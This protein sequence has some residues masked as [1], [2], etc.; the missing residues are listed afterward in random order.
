VGRK[1]LLST[2]KFL[3]F[4]REWLRQSL[5][6][7][8]KVRRI[9]LLRAHWSPEKASRATTKRGERAEMAW[10]NDKSAIFD[11]KTIDPNGGFRLAE[12]GTR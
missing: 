4:R 8:V 3:G 10:S 1:P 6:S 12:V 2:G 9:R 5:R 11:L 7:D